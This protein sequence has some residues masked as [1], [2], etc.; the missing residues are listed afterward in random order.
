MEVAGDKFAQL[1]AISALPPTG[2]TEAAFIA[3]R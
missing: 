2:Q 1:G 3:E